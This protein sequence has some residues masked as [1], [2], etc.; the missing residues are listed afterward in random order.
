[1]N[2]VPCDTVLHTCCALKHFLFPL[3]LEMGRK[4]KQGSSTNISQVCGPFKSTKEHCDTQ[5]PTILL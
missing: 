4:Q 5:L 2:W 1:M 3:S